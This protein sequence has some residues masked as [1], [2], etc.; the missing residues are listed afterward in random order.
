[1]KL[2]RSLLALSALTA[3]TVKNAYLYPPQV[4]ERFIISMGDTP[5]PHESLGYVQITR[6][7][8]DLFG[9]FPIV[10]ADLQRV[11]GEELVK[12][13]EARGADGIINLRFHERQW[14][15]AQRLL[16]ALPPVFLFPLPTEAEITGE[17][18]KLT[19]SQAAPVAPT[20]TH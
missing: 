20:G 17:L 10:D 5:R 13:L 6:K 9:F 8:A 16:F 3:C 7:G 15:T 2:M 1:M 18:I 11:L 12:E 4:R 14:T 19:P